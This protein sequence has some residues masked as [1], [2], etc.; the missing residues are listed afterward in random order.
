M[1]ELKGFIEVNSPYS[2]MVNIYKINDFHSYSDGK[3]N[4]KIYFDKD[5]YIITKESYEEI[6]ELIKK[7]Q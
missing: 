5:N 6:K 7:A 2:R 4:C 3:N 1:E